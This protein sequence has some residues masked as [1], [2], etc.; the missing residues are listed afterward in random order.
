MSEEN[1]HGPLFYGNAS[2]V[3]N[4]YEF[5]TLLWKTLR[6]SHIPTKSII[7]KIY[8]ISL[9]GVLNVARPEL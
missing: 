4:S 9:M 6:V 8:M 7:N 2:N 5:T 1:F 3:E